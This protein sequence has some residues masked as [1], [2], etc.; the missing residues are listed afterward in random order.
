LSG[1]VKLSSAIGTAADFNER[2]VYYR[3]S[4]LYLITASW[5]SHPQ[6]VTHPLE[7]PALPATLLFLRRHHLPNDGGQHFAAEP[8]S[9][10]A[11][12]P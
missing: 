6:Q 5:T 10:R 3:N 2:K 9:L 8:K 1:L 12:A 11:Q 4:L 7:H